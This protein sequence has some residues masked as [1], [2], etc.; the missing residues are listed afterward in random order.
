M[1]SSLVVCRPMVRTKESGAKKWSRDELE[2]LSLP[3]RAVAMLQSA[4][5]IIASVPSS[6]WGNTPIEE[7]L[8]EVMEVMPQHGMLGGSFNGVES[9][10]MMEEMEE[11]VRNMHVLTQMLP[12]PR[13]RWPVQVQMVKCC[14]RCAK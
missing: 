8:G 10:A 3:N 13:A 11:T 6:D 1:R 5:A 14:R 4:A 9:D 2:K 7:A 12:R